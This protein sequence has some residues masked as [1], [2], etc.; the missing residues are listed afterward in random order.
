MIG[1]GIPDPEELERFHGFYKL[2]K[3]NTGKY[4]G[5]CDY[6]RS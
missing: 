4:V 5:D 6:T 2:R 1:G 3:L